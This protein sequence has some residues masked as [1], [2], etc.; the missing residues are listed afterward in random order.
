MDEEAC[1]DKE[2]FVISRSIMIIIFL[3]IA[4][5]KKNLVIVEKKFDYS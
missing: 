4:H 3:I 2:L 1:H 5:L